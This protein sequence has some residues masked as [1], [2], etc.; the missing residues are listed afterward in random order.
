[1]PPM[2]P[3]WGVYFAVADIEVSVAQAQSLGATLYLPP[4]DIMKVE[5][6]PPVGRFAALADPQGAAFSILQDLP[7][8]VDSGGKVDHPAPPAGPFPLT[9]RPVLII[10][11]RGGV[12]YMSHDGVRSTGTEMFPR[13]LHY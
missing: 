7:P 1:M 12:S 6:Q 10:I 4:T 2:P 13:R 8:G 9:Y 11:A 3:H 5:G